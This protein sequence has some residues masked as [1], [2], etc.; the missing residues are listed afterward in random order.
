MDS[1]GTRD[2]LCD[3]VLGFSA[4]RTAQLSCQDRLRVR[5]VLTARADLTDVK[6]R[7]VGGLPGRAVAAHEEEAGHDDGERE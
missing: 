7:L 6:M 3:L 4:E 2:E 5:L 1:A